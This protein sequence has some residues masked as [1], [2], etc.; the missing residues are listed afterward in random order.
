[1]VQPAPRRRTTEA[2][3]GTSSFADEFRERRH[4]DQRAQHH[5]RASLRAPRLREASAVIP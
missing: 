1:V 3:T 2:R 5:L 4:A